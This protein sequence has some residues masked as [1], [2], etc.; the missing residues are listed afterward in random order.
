M[1]KAI[2]PDKLP[3]IVL[4][5]C[6]EFL[7][8]CVTAVVNFGLRTGLKLTEYGRKRMSH[9][10][11]KRAKKIWLKIIAPY[12]CFP[13]FLKFKRGVWSPV[14]SHMSR[15]SCT[16]ISTGFKKGSHVLLN[17]WKYFM[18]LAVPL[19]VDSSVT[20]YIWTSLRRLTLYVLQNW[21]Q[22]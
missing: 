12:S 21:C 9:P 6:A 5:E 20:S 19:I 2:G 11:T 8:P 7:A 14:W 15:R 22:N 18:R 17:F 10:F 3:T 13:L 1:H 4:K 16:P